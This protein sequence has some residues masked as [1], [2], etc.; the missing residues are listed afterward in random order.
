MLAITLSGAF[1]TILLLG[2]IQGFILCGL[3]FSSKKNLYSNRILAS[4]ILLMTL[5][6]FN[7]YGEYE[8]WFGSRIIR[9]MADIV[10]LVLV[11]P[12]G[13]LLWFYVQ[14]ILDPSFKITKKQRFH[15]Y[16]VIADL[17]PSFVVIIYI[18]GHFAGI[19][20]SKPGPWGIF[21]D[22][23][24]VYA[25]I[26]RWISV[27]TYVWLSAKFLKAYKAKLNGTLNGVAY[28]YKWLRQFVRAFMIFQS[29][30]FLYL[31]PYV[32]PKY[33]DKILETFDWYPVY[34]PMAILI[35]WLGIKGYIISQMQTAADKKLNAAGAI[36]P[37]LAN[38]VLT[39]LVKAMS[40]DKIYLNSNLNLAVLSEHTGIA[41]KT[42]SAVLNQHLHKSFNEFLNGY[43]VNEFKEKI[44]R[45]DMNNLT[46]AGIAFE[47]GFNS[48]ATFQRTFKELTGQSP[49]EYRKSALTLS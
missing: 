6:C 41:A 39:T 11:M 29:V 42:I 9:L 17:V 48:Q 19:I 45:P 24:N 44:R 38:E 12:F 26:P 1:K 33:T 23:Y 30:W 31:I 2:S 27:T 4:L 18:I 32:I 5:A 46:I 25:D 37:Q 3:L 10:P 43:R 36:S 8:N 21:I 47:C 7:L 34:I 49:S 40:E 22:T 13:P 28:N 14:S 20:K 16:P 15:F 35:Y